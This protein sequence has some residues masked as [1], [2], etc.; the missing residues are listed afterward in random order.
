VE[1]HARLPV[2][3]IWLVTVLA[4]WVLT[5][6]LLAVLISTGSAHVA[7]GARPR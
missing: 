4:S 7:T 6:A 2:G 5:T 3:L 1:R